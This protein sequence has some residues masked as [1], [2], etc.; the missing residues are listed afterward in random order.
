[1]SISTGNGV[2]R[3]VVRSAYRNQLPAILSRAMPIPQLP[4]PPVPP[5]HT[6]LPSK[7]LVNEFQPTANGRYYPPHRSFEESGSR[8]LRRPLR[9]RTKPIA[10][11]KL[12][13]RDGEQIPLQQARMSEAADDGIE[14][15]FEKNLSGEQ[16]K[17]KNSALE[18]NNTDKITQGL[19][20]KWTYLEAPIGLA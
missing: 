8:E 18:C 17:D 12:D 6:Q 11:D 15:N 13:N 4:L 1:M 9:A 7:S 19:F 5:S 10:P 2:V 16:E 20:H 3:Q 14:E